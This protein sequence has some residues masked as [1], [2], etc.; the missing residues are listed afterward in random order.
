VQ[1]YT[2]SWSP[3]VDVAELRG[4]LVEKLQK[5]L[6]G[7][8]TG[9]LE[10]G[11]QPLLTRDVEYLLPLGAV[12]V[13]PLLERRVEPYLVETRVGEP[14]HILPTAGDTRV[15]VGMMLRAE[16][17][18][19]QLDVPTGAFEHLLWLAPGDRGTERVHPLCLLYD[20][21]VGLDR[22]LVC[23]HL[24]HVLAV[25]TE[26]TVKTVALVT[27]AVDEKHHLATLGTLLTALRDHSTSGKRSIL[28]NCA[29]QA[30]PSNGGTGVGGF[31]PV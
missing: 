27:V 19:Q 2:F 17:V 28:K 26:R 1:K 29:V 11:C 31:C 9:D 20:V 23:V 21:L 5:L 24:T 12:Q 6:L 25:L 13:T 30:D 7:A 4:P 14:A 16:L 15:Q 10:G 18:F 22:P 8:D 3:I